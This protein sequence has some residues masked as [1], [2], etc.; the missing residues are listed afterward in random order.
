MTILDRTGTTRR[1]RIDAAQLAEELA[2]RVPDTD[3]LDLAKAREAAGGVLHDATAVAR[4][5]LARAGERARTL[6]SDVAH[7]GERV[8]ADSPFDELGPRIRTVASTTAIRAIIARLERE[9]PDTDKDRYDR[10]YTRGRVQARS[11]YLGLG[12]AVGIAAGVVAAALLEPR[13]GKER[14]DRLARGTRG[15]A[16]GLRGRAAATVRVA[17]D[18]ARTV[19]QDRGLAA[20]DVDVPGATPA[21]PEAPVMAADVPAPVTDVPAVTL[22][23]GAVPVMDEPSPVASE[24]DAAAPPA[25]A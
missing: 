7:A 16:S 5:S 6:R 2:K 24:D 9:L 10:A 14:R 8:G 21:E 13:H 12:I 4:E 22:P 11:V 19:A 20:P 18:R 17:Q 15:L 25:Q 1:I 3:Q 23:E